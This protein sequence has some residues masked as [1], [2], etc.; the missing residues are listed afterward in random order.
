[1]PHYQILRCE[2][3]QEDCSYSWD[4]KLTEF[5]YCISNKI[6]NN[7]STGKWANSINQL[8]STVWER[9][10][11][12]F[13]VPQNFAARLLM[14]NEGLPGLSSLRLRTE[15]LLVHFG[16][17]TNLRFQITSFSRKFSFHNYKKPTIPNNCWWYRYILWISC[18]K[19]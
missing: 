2:A 13:L 9:D 4:V 15:L 12:Y 11:P 18:V 6:I 5:G 3:N 8:V 19:P 10:G 17:L 1:M 14:S 16:R 7:L